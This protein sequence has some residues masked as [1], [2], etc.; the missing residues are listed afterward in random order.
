V[1][2][3]R[4]FGLTAIFKLAIGAGKISKSAVGA[5]FFNNLG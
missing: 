4:G 5:S 2:S 3:N 1:P